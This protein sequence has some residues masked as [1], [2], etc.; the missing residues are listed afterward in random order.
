MAQNL[1][2]FFGFSELH[3]M[4]DT[5]SSK[6]SKKVFYLQHPSRSRD[7]STDVLGSTLP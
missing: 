2:D 7:D 4:G 5:L 1:K 3:R 6:K